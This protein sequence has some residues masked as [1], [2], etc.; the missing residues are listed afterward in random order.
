MSNR[1]LGVLV[2]Y[3]SGN[4]F[5]GDAAAKSNAFAFRFRY[6]GEVCKSELDISSGIYLGPLLGMH[7]L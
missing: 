7:E 6:D 3:L 5:T 2:Q 4:T 1:L